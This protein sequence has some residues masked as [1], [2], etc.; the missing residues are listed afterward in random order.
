MS[1]FLKHYYQRSGSIPRRVLVEVVPDE[2]PL[3][4]QWLGQMAGAKVE[5]RLPQR[6]AKRELMELARKNAEQSLAQ[7]KLRPSRGSESRRQ[8]LEELQGA[9]GLEEPPWRIECV[10]ISNFQGRQAVGCRGPTTTGAFAS[11]AG[12]RPTIFA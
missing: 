8:S 2:A 3:L 12:I 6:G 7:E 1:A 9:L 11:G 5:I 4:S 10:D